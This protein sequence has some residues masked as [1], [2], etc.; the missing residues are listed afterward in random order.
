MIEQDLII[1]GAGPAGLSAAKVALEAGLR[2]TIFERGVAVGGQL[3]KQTHKFFGSKEQYAKTRGIEIAKILYN[4]LLPYRDHLTIELE[5]TVV[6]IYHDYVVTVL[7]KEKYRKYKAK[8]IIIAT[9]ASEK[10]LGFVN[11][12]LPGVYGAGAVQTLMNLYG[13]IPGKEV[14]MV[15]SG[16]IGLIVSYQLIQAGVRVKALVEAAPNIGGY[17]VHASKLKRLGV[18]ILVS[19]TI[20]E[21]MGNDSVEK[22]VIVS[23]DENWEMIP[24]TERVIFADTICIAVGLSPLHQLL[25]MLEIEMRYI[26][27]L[28]GLVPL[29]NDHLETSMKNVYVAGDVSGIEE[30]SSAMVEGSLAGLYAAKELKMPHHDHERLE[31]DLHAQLTNLR[32]GPCGLKTRNGIKKLKESGPC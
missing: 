17:K 3:V 30:A 22:A 29:V 15:G 5:A 27:E 10:M 14:I 4:N 11:N 16:N 18:P 8:A 21:V 13:V 28:G 20:K 25:S 31:R 7:E 2:V 26:P 24:G 6:A 9:G 32:F 19:T 1:V 23:L 12:D